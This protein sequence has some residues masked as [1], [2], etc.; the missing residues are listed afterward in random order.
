MLVMELGGFSWSDAIKTSTTCT[1][2][3]FTNILKKTPSNFCIN[4]FVIYNVVSK[5]DVFFYVNTLAKKH[6]R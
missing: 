6:S 3:S 2:L 1:T 4:I 5:M